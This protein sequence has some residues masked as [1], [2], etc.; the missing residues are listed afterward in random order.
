LEI[1][2]VH[3]YYHRKMET[4]KEDFHH[5]SNLNNPFE[6]QKFS[7]TDVVA[8]SRRLAFLEKRLIRDSLR[9]VE[10]DEENKEDD[11]EH[12]HPYS[13][14][15]YDYIAGFGASKQDAEEMLAPYGIEENSQCAYDYITTEEEEIESLSW[16]ERKIVEF[17]MYDAQYDFN[18]QPYFA[19]DTFRSKCSIP[20]ILRS[21]FWNPVY[22]EFTSIQ[23]FTW[24]LIIGI[25]MGLF[26]ALWHWWIK[27]GIHFFWEQLPLVLYRAGMFTDV[28]GS[29]PLFHY[30]W[31][32]PTLFG[33]LLSYL[34]CI[35]PDKIPTQDEWIKIVHDQGV[36]ERC[37]SFFP[38]F[39]LSTAA[40]WSGLALGPELPL[41]LTGGMIGSWIGIFTEQTV[42]Q[43]RVLNLTAASAAVSA[44]F[45]FPM[46]G[47]LFV[48][49]V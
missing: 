18:D 46:A 25:A 8:R 33:G 34:H 28:D 39:F 16:I 12:N 29:F 26:T 24:A 22:T 35:L 38:L 21:L 40:M 47:A 5:V 3:V 45:G 43:A 7:N 44:F 30:V 49:E 20:A 17:L 48:L 31:I 10:E 14:N 41:I 1:E 19:D 32:L 23:L 42:L 6:V 11:D 27:I 9:T 37:Q 15:E 4:L 36:D 13:D 2:Q